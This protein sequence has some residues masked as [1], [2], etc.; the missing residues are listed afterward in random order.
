MTAIKI[1]DGS[2]PAAKPWN[3][4]KDLA[5]MKAKNLLSPKLV[6]KN[7]VQDVAAN[8]TGSKEA[9]IDAAPPKAIE[10]V[11]KPALPVQTPQKSSATEFDDAQTEDEVAEEF[12]SRH[13]STLRFDHDRGKWYVWSERRWLL[14]KTRLAFDFARMLCREL[15]GDQKR[16]GSKAAADGVEVMA[17]RSHKLAVQSD[18]W[19]KDPYL[20]GTPGGTVDLVTGE[21]LPPNPS[22]YI[23]KQCRVAPAAPG[24][25]CLAFDAFLDQVT[26]GDTGLQ[27]LLLQWAG[28]S[29]T[30]DTKEQTLLFIYG[31]GGNGKSVLQNVFSEIMAEYSEIAA[32][33]TFAS[34]KNQRHLTELAMLA[35]ARLVA[36]SETEKGQSWSE[37]RINGLTGGDN[38]TANFMRTDHFTF[39]PQFKLMIVGNHKPQLQSVNDAARRRFIIIPFEHKP[40][41]PDREL[42]A[43]L[44]H[45]YPA[46]LRRMIEGGID[47]QKNGLVIPGVVK[48][49]TDDYFEE[50]DVL[51]RF[52][53]EACETGPDK[54]DS[55]ANLF[56]AWKAWCMVNGEPAGSQ[57]SF[58]NALTQRGFAKKKSG[59]TKYLG[60]QVKA[61]E[62]T[63]GVTSPVVED[64]TDY[65]AQL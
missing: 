48:A 14:N 29:L 38:I 45:E 6:T 49:A 54:S 50:Q 25:A 40:K 4:A 47:W 44:R 33:D 28:Y 13:E 36:V 8:D 55:A 11:F 58:G 1:A 61:W 5:A 3:P 12:I 19:D 56:Y 21:L 20:L 37:N 10:K 35:G 15:R 64:S 16:L 39:K 32:M 62:G 31:P 26:A 60:I 53:G 24:T 18:I 65:G 46:I 2:V 9:K 43:K 42:A 22:D 63:G 57:T 17:Q 7:P 52:I 30:G 27:R 41:V 34:S 59:S 51:G 23:S